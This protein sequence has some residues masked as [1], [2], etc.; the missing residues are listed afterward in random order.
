M[1]DVVLE[2]AVVPCIWDNKEQIYVPVYSHRG[3]EIKDRIE[4]LEAAHERTAHSLHNYINLCSD[5]MDREKQLKA[6]LENL[7]STFMELNMAHKECDC[8]ECSVIRE[9]RAALGGEKKE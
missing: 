1:T 7:F 3:V 2:A 4:Q 5:L 6:A 9:A 8:Q